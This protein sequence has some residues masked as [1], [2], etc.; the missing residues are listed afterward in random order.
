MKNRLITSALLLALVCGPSLRA[1][2][3]VPP[4]TEESVTVPSEEAEEEGTP[5]QPAT[6]DGANSA[7]RERWKNITIALVTVAA[8]VTAII[9]VSTNQGSSANSS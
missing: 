8:A 7:R 1:E 9:L 4:T 2:D 3:I 6:L 5:V